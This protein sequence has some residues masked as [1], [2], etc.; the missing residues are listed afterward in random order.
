[1]GGC[2]L[3]STYW[4]TAAFL[5]ADD[6]RRIYR[7]PDTAVPST[8]RND[9]PRA[10]AHGP[11]ELPL[12]LPFFRA[13]SALSVQGLLLPPSLS[14]FCPKRFPPAI[15]SAPPRGLGFASV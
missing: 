2:A 1:M 5:A 8:T 7:S 15:A 4:R 6:T 3:L 14:M 13:V 11:I 9:E 12:N 10:H